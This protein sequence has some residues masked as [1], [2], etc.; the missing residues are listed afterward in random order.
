MCQAA[1]PAVDALALQYQGRAVFI[2]QNVDAPIGNRISRFWAAF[3]DG[4]AYLPL[5]ILDS[6]H[7]M[8]TGDLG[9]FT[10]VFQ[11]L[12][13][14][15]LAR[16]PQAEIEAYARQVGTR[17]RVYARLH[18]TSGTTLAA[19]T[20]QAALHALVYED[21][22]VGVTERIMRA[23]PWLDLA[24]PLAPDGVFCA[25]LDTD[26]LSGVAWNALHTVVAADYTP[27]SG[28]VFDMLQ[29]AAARPAGLT[30]EPSALVVG[31][32]S[33]HPADRTVPVTLAGPY[34]LS[35]TAVPDVPWLVLTP[36]AAAIATRPAVTVA[37]GALARGPQEGHVTFSATSQDGMAFTQFLTVTAVLGPRLV[38]A[39]AAP[40]TPGSPIA[41]PIVMSALGDEHEVS[42]SLAFDP[43]MLRAPSVAAGSGAAAATLAVDD[44]EASSGRRGV[45]L[46]L[47]AG[48]ALPEGDDQLAVVTFAT[49]ATVPRPSTVVEFS[50]QP[51][52][53]SISDGLGNPLTAAVEGATLVF[54]DASVRRVVRR[55]LPRSGV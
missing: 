43:V 23:A 35:W 9:N 37:A 2:E 46:T 25:T 45:T 16:P 52:A 7:R 34:T 17:M 29:A 48:Q 44:S 18:N 33:G 55:R 49:A 47:P 22:H 24:A 30:V 54:P 19:S 40:V 11:R 4:T 50:D 32:D 38:R 5:V 53:R 14:A 31:V 39:V 13:E 3:N 6:G 20:N 1:G 51:V 15:E 27:G 10:T 21:K 26:A 42:F 8:T 36:D 12:V 41:L 28:P